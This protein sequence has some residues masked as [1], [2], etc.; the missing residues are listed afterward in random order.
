LGLLW[1]LLL[2]LGL[3]VRVKELEL[4]FEVMVGLLRTELVLWLELKN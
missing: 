4:V 1:T 3:M 2:W